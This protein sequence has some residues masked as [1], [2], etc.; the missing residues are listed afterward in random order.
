AD[1]FKVVKDIVN[2]GIESYKAG[3]KLDA[4]IERVEKDFG[5]VLTDDDK[6]LLAAYKKSARAYDDNTDS[7]KN[8]S[9]L[10]KMEDDRVAFL[11]AAE[12]NSSLNGDFRF[13]IKLALKEFAKAENIALESA[14]NTI[15]KYAETDEQ[16]AEVRKAFDDA[17]RK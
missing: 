17:K 4:L 13:E 8:D 15:E 12:R 10:Q 7:D 5:N 1:T 14:S 16:R 6:K 2:G 11:E 3:E 9:L